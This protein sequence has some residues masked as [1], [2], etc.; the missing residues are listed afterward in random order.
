MASSSNC[1]RP[2]EA[3]RGTAILAYSCP[4]RDERNE[5][6]FSCSPSMAVEVMMFYRMTFR[7]LCTSLS[8]PT[9]PEHAEQAPLSLVAGAQQRGKRFGLPVEERPVGL[10]RT[11]KGSFIDLLICELTADGAAYS[12]YR[13]AQTSSRGWDWPSFIKCS[14]GIRNHGPFRRPMWCR[15]PG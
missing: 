3:C 12:A 15:N 11:H 9:A 1:A 7:L 8:L 14:G 6:T 5:S 4:A 13:P 2:S 10:L